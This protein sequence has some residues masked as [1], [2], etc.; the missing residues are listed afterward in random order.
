MRWTFL[1]AVALVAALIPPALLAAGDL[2]AETRPAP[3]FQEWQ[4]WEVKTGRLLPFDEWAAALAPLEVIYIGEEHHNARHIEAALRILNT[5][6][7]QGRQPALAMEMFGWDGQAALDR[8]LADKDWAR[9]PFLREVHWEAN[10]GG[11]FDDY[12][13]LPAFAR[14]QHLPL[15]AL[16]PPKSLVRL[17]A[18]RGLAQALTDPDMARWGMNDEVFVDDA[19]YHDMIVTPLR[20]CHGG[21]TDEAYRR[22]YEASMFRDEGMAKTIADALRRRQD[23]SAPE[24]KHRVGPIVSYTGGGHVQYRLPVPNRVLRRR[25]GSVKQATIYLTSFEPGRADELRRLMQE[26]VAD[27]LWLTPLGARGAPERCR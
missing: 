21:L 5:L 24:P 23:G 8:Y 10:W 15:L 14:A 20:Q 1:A 11:A 19:A 27:Y 3:A 2:P 4:V 6:V 26:N 25:E 9:E 7:A 16:N 18:K 12:E 17:V 22:M 13:P